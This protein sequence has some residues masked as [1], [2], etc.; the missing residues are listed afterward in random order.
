MSREF[1]VNIKDI[2]LLL[3]KKLHIIAAGTV[4]CGAF[5]AAISFVLLNPV[6]ES[7]VMFYIDNGNYEITTVS[8]ISA[9]RSLVDSYKVIL[10]TRDCLLEIISA[11]K[12][13]ITPEKAGKM[14]FAE[15]VENTEI[16]RV[17][18]SAEKPV[19]AKALAD[20]VA[21]ILPEKGAEIIGGS[22]A[23]II[24]NPVLP[25]APSSPEHLENIII[26]AA[27]GFVSC[28]GFFVLREIYFPEKETRKSP[29]A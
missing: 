1:E 12:A 6:Y 8:D 21:S 13:D 16:L 19:D 25:S 2:F 18:V 20:A 29:A 3:I 11:A 26:G 9:S 5:A 22:S 15:A 14:I 24:E 7:S 23:K 4:F 17:T 10:G 28:A 27:L